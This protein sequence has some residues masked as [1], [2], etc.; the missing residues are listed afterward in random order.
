M[1]Q[2]IALITDFGTQ[3][4]FAGELKGVLLRHSPASII[5][6]IT[7]EIPAG[8]SK[9][10]SFILWACYKSF[11]P[12]TIFCICIDSEGAL[13]KPIIVAELN[14]YVFI[15]FDNGAL[16]SIHHENSFTTIR[17][18]SSEQVAISEIKSPTFTARDILAPIAAQIANGADINSIGLSGKIQNIYPQSVLK[19]KENS[20]QG[21]ILYFD[22]F[23]NAI[24]SIDK[25]YLSGIDL[26]KISLHI[27]GTSCKI[28]KSYHDVKVKSVLGYIGSL[29]LLEIAINQGSAKD[30]LKLQLGDPIEAIILSDQ[31]Q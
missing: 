22:H 13:S 10:A 7:H 18:I 25:R 4:W 11:P 8:E 3:D 26:S 24:T 20:I 31:N 1:T 5:I 6:D 30:L 15:S 19:T 2:V 23:G 16:S 17:T 27:K 28:V 14:S 21:E 29:G 9:L 12:K